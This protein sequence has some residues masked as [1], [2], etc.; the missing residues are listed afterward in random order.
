MIRLKLEDVNKKYS[1]TWVKCNDDGRSKYFREKF[2]SEFGG[3]FLKEGR[4]Y[5]W[6]EIPKP[7]VVRRKFVFEGPD[8]TIHFIENMYDFCKIHDLKRSAMYEL[9]AGKRNH[10]KQ[11]KFISEIPWQT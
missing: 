9:I 7:T 11:F 10:H 2:L 8:G 5:R 4:E 6:R 1:Q 3:E